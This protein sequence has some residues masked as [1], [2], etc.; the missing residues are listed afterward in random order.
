MFAGQPF[1]LRGTVMANQIL[2]KTLH[3]ISF[4][5]VQQVLN[6]LGYYMER[7][8]TKSRLIHWRLEADKSEVKHGGPPLLTIGEPDFCCAA[9]GT[10]VY[11]RDYIVDLLTSALNGNFD[12]DGTVLKAL[13][14]KTQLRH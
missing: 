5:A 3:P 7:Q 2:P 12:K 10:T 6:R 14:A 13:L 4:E 1:S 8:E 9:S 11:D